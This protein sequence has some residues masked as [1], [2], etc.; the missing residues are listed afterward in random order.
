[1]KF[2]K[3]E[4][5]VEWKGYLQVHD[6]IRGFACFMCNDERFERLMLT[7]DHAEGLNLSLPK[8][9][10]LILKTREEAEAMMAKIAKLN[11]FS[12]LEDNI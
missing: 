3:I 8:D 4:N 1:M 12:K 10:R 9:Y 7:R 11:G 2:V 6:T 5:G